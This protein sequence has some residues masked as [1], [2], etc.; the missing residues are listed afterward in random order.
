MT[1]PP[2][3][4]AAAA[5]YPAAE[6]AEEEHPAWV[7]DALRQHDRQAAGRRACRVCSSCSRRAA[8]TQVASPGT[9]RSV[10]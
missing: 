3:T 9:A 2:V 1:E 6:Q 5:P 10:M 7:R 4:E 8:S